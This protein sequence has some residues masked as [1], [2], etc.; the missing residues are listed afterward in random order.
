MADNIRT[1]FRTRQ[2]DLT[3]SIALEKK[4]A[5]IAQQQLKRCRDNIAELEVRLD[6][7]ARQMRELSIGDEDENVIHMHQHKA[8]SGGKKGS[9]TKPNLRYR[10]PGPTTDLVALAYENTGIEVE[11]LIGKVQSLH[12]GISRPTVMKLI[13]RMIKEEYATR[14]KTRFY[15]TPLCKEAWEGSH[16]FRKAAANA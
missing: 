8:R 4:N 13:R 3:A 2:A 14:D 1:Y 7:V 5:E 15:L 11:E 9:R 10:H 6:E 12:V 16:L